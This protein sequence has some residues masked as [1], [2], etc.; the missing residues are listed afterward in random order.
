MGFENSVCIS[1]NNI[2]CHGIPN[3]RQF[4]DGDFVNFDITCYKDG[5]FGDTSKMIYFGA[6]D[7]RIL[8]LGKVEGDEL[9]EVEGSAL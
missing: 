2:I 7:P 4:K 6:V 5:F 9:G 3:N 8:E 1:P